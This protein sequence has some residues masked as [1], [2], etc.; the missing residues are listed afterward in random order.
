M[1]A[2]RFIGAIAI[3]CVGMAGHGDAQKPAKRSTDMPV[4]ELAQLRR[5]KAVLN[6]LLETWEKCTGQLNTETNELTWCDVYQAEV[7]QTP[8]DMLVEPKLAIQLKAKLTAGEIE[9]LRRSISNAMT[10]GYYY[11]KEKAGK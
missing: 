3:L 2:V 7:L 6:G 4:E 5:A 8:L 10:G 11:G 1:R 9:S